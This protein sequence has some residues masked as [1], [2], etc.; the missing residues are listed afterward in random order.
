MPF[1]LYV[2]GRSTEKRHYKP[3][4]SEGS[5]PLPLVLYGFNH[6]DIFPSPA[7]GKSLCVR[8]I[9]A[10]ELVRPRERRWDIVCHVSPGKYVTTKTFGFWGQDECQTIH[11]N[12]MCNMN[13]VAEFE[14]LLERTS[15]LSDCSPRDWTTMTSD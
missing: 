6:F 8:T 5:G 11:P 9:K 4:G 1:N 10:M 2:R 14:H 12:Y 3:S 7:A 13:M 15:L